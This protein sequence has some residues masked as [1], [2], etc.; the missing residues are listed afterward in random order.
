M[1]DGGS[2]VVGIAV[3][4]VAI[5]VVVVDISVELDEDVTIRRSTVLRAANSRPTT[6]PWSE[7]A[8]TVVSA[9]VPEARKIETTRAGII[10]AAINT[11]N[12]ERLV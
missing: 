9:A 7:P 10:T 5:E 6:E 4:V 3:V 12:S 1:L 2:V 11:K 8:N